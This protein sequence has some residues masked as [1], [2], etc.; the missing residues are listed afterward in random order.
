MAQLLVAEVEAVLEDGFREAGISD[1][2]IS[3]WCQNS[4]NVP[5]RASAFLPPNCAAKGFAADF[6][7]KGM[8]VSECYEG[9]S[10][11]DLGKMIKGLN[12][13]PP[14]WPSPSSEQ[15]IKISTFL[16]ENGEGNDHREL[17]ILMSHR[18]HYHEDRELNT[19]TI[20][21]CINSGEYYI[22]LQPACDCVRLTEATTFLFC[23]LDLAGGG[24]ATH[25][26][27][28]DGALVDLR[29]K[30]EI[31]KSVTIAFEPAGGVVLAESG[32]LVSDVGSYKWIAQL[33]PKHAHRAVEQ[34]TRELSRVGLTESEWLRLKAT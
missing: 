7:T 20:L 5:S 27:R 28:G 30:P 23:K 33:K 31:G 22:C 25:V 34:F 26:V 14:K 4:W 32:I 6:C 9:D 17:S 15:F 16:S 21:Q 8:G 11:S 12:K 24:L 18:T 19:G 2:I 13:Q 1:K 3:D 10:R 29:Y